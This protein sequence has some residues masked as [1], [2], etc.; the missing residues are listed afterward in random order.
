[1]S[2]SKNQYLKDRNIP[3]VEQMFNSF[4]DFN[5][6]MINSGDMNEAVTE[7]IRKEDSDKAWN[8]FRANDFQDDEHLSDY[9][10]YDNPAEKEILK[11]LKRQRK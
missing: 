9:D 10:P 3:N 6:V 2:V 5:E 1:M 8:D 11:A 7:R 4:K